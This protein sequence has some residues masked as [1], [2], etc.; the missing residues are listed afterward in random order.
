M[1]TG[2]SPSKIQESIEALRAQYPSVD[3][4]PL[5]LISRGNR[6]FVRR[7]PRC[8]SWDDIPAVDV[9]INNAGVMLLPRA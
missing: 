4:R 8:F 9:L 5:Q 7:R 6:R 2:R 3:Y 1:L